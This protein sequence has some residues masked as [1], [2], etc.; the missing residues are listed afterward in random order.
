[1]DLRGRPEHAVQIHVRRLPGQLDADL[2]ARRF[3]DCVWLATQR[4]M[5]TLRQACGQ[6]AGRGVGARIRSSCDAH[7]LV[8]ATEG[9]TGLSDPKTF[10]DIW[11]VPLS[12]EKKE[13]PVLQTPADERNPQVSPDGKWI[14]YSSNETGRS[15]I[16]IRPFPEGPGNIQ[17]SVN[18]G[19]FPRWRRDGRQ[20]HFLNLVSLGA[21][22]ASDIRVTGASVQRDVPRSVFQTLYVTGTHPGGS[23]TCT[24]FPPTASG[25]SF[26]SSTR[27]RAFQIF[28]APVAATNAAIATVISVVA[29][30]R[31]AGT[32]SAGVSTAPI[33]AVLNWTT[34]LKQ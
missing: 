30:D 26:R 34:A 23:T 29:A 21:M 15:E 14:A 32:I 9:C 11:S 18:G 13:V 24:R 12:G 16:Y 10:G 5:G 6:H 28:R 4:Q 27:Y 1:M 25:S 2:V 3:P 8:P 7:E 19:V 31:N 22:M 33:T 20:L 17:L